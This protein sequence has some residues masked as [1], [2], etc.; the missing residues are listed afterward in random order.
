MQFLLFVL[1]LVQSG[2]KCRVRE[3]LLMSTLFAQA[4]LVEYQNSVAY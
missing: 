2:S 3:Q 1:Q 4:A